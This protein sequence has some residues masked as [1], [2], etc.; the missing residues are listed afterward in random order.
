MRHLSHLFQH[1]AVKKK[2]EKKERFICN[3][4]LCDA[5]QECCIFCKVFHHDDVEES[6]VCHWVLVLI[7][8]QEFCHNDD[9]VKSG[10][11]PSVLPQ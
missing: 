5:V 8:C 6:H 10:L 11:L 4:E 3:Q 7:C 1:S 2:R 9:D